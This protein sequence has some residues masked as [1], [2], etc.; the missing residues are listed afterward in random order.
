MQTKA[1]KLNRVAKFGYSALSGEASATHL[2]VKSFHYLLGKT[3]DMDLQMVI[4]EG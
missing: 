3:E 4:D 1:E 2:V